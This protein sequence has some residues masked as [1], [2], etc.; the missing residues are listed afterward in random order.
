MLLY[1]SFIFPQNA[2]TLKFYLPVQIIIDFFT[3][4]VLEFKIPTFMGWRLRKLIQQNNVGVSSLQLHS[5]VVIPALCY[6]CIHSEF[7]MKSTVHM[8]TLTSQKTL[9]TIFR[10]TTHSLPQVSSHTTEGWVNNNSLITHMSCHF[11]Q[12]IRSKQIINLSHF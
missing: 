6:V 4:C 10:S 9:N 7:N 11:K 3:T 2:V 1:P 8:I 12:Q 5:S